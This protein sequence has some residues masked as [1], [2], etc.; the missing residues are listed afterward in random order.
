MDL[1]MS[2]QA[3]A[4]LASALGGAVL[5]AFFDI[6]RAIRRLIRHKTAATAAE[7]ALFW[8]AATLLMFWL[9]MLVNHGTMRFYPLLGAALGAVLYLLTISNTVIKIVI[10]VLRAIYFPLKKAKRGLKKAVSYVKMKIT[11]LRE[12]MIRGQDDDQNGQNDQNAEHD[13]KAGSKRAKRARKH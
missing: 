1:S 9:L 13:N 3:F 7:D 5:G 10:I 11:T 6:F 8:I 4:F 12:R 2:G